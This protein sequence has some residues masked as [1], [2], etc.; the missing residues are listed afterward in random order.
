[1]ASRKGSK[2][3]VR[4]HPAKMKPLAPKPA[5]PKP[6]KVSPA[7]AKIA[8][9][10][11]AKATKKAEP[12]IL[13]IFLAQLRE[14]SERGRL[15]EPTRYIPL[16][17]SFTVLIVLLILLL[18]SGGGL[19]SGAVAGVA[20]TPITE[21][22]LNHWIAIN[23][24]S[25]K[26]PVPVPPNYTSCIDLKQLAVAK[27]QTAPSHEA[28]KSECATA[29]QSLKKRTLT[30]LLS[31][32]WTLKQASALGISIPDK[33]VK[34]DFV[35][36]KTKQFPQPA[37]FQK[38]LTS[39]GETVSDILLH[40]KLQLLAT[41]IEQK[42]KAGVGPVT[43]AEVASYYA[44]NPE[45][46]NT[47]IKYNLKI[48]LTKTLA[49]AKTAKKALSSGVSWAREAKR[50]SV[51]PDTKDKGGVI[52]GVEAG[53]QERQ[54]ADAISTAKTGTITGPVQTVFGY[55][56]FVITAQTPASHET[57]TQAEASIKAQLTT[58][59]PNDAWKKF[60]S[61]F[62]KGWT[63]QTECRSGFVVSDCRAYKGSGTSTAPTTTQPSTTTPV[64]PSTPTKVVTAPK[65]K[66]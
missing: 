38:F 13:A 14:F 4:Y 27:G 17:S 5:H 53:S 63:A 61:S 58:S 66:K 64:Q 59:R 28:L 3:P 42:V 55:Y 9:A 21:T 48:I 62:T 34:A 12:S 33:T 23:A 1:M 6:L 56:V 32:E 10:N 26:Q 52:L 57:L 49:Q 11:K 2:K 18:S 31:S 36:E 40:I 7:M 16:L 15:N 43:S 25:T 8:R 65:P 60:T 19:P 54:L 24:A 37:A 39:S 22:T 45:S 30:Y 41:Q 51:D 46:F 44:A 35:Q 50:A 20:G 29:Y 47:P